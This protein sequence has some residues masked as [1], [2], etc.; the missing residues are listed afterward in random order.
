MG[1]DISLTNSYTDFCHQ[2]DEINPIDF[3]YSDFFLDR[4]DELRKAADEERRKKKIVNK[5]F[6]LFGCRQI[7]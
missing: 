3:T 1:N 6:T 4:D 5:Q 7:C 2:I